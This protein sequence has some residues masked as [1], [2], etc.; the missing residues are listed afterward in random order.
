[1]TADHSSSQ[2]AA[3]FFPEDELRIVRLARLFWRV[4]WRTALVIFLGYLCYLGTSHYLIQTV[5][6]DG[7]SMYPTLR[8]DDYY[9]LQRW[10]YHFY[11]DPAP[12]DI[13]VIKDPS[14]QCYAVKRIIAGPGDSVYV[15]DGDIFVNGK[16]LKEPYLPP[17]TWT[18]P[19][20]LPNEQWMIACQQGEYVVMGDNRIYSFDSRYYGVVPKS[21]ILGIIFH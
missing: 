15:T 11:R 10:Y 3:V 19:A 18:F 9:I 13:V 7:I 4:V 14:N 2:A 8:N 17:S 20:E 21:N 6:V 5:K 1:M 12:R 16:K